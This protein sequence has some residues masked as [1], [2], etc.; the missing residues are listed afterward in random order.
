MFNVHLMAGFPRADAGH[1]HKETQSTSPQES[2]ATKDFDRVPEEKTLVQDRETCENVTEVHA[3]SLQGGGVRW[4]RVEG[5]A[6]ASIGRRR[7]HRHR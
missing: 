7:A 5:H 6:P 3:T 4:S 2:D 1:N